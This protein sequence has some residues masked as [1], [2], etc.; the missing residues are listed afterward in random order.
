MRDTKS[1]ALINMDE[2]AKNEYRSKVKL[3]N[4]QKEEINKVRTEI[5][6]IK[7]DM[8]EIKLLLEKLL[9]KGTNG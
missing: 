8:C 6:D 1:M 7:S 9:E 4:T 3:L 2:T 5:N